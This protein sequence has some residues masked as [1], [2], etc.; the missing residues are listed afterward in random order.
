M[1]EV[2][3]PSALTVDPYKPEEIA[4]ALLDLETDN[5]LYQNQRNYGLKQAQQFSWKKTADELTNIYSKILS[6]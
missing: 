3:G 4:C 5:I 2:A 1:P 6:S